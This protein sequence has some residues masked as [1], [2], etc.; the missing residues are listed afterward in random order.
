M[1]HVEGTA[2]ISHQDRI[3]LVKFH[4]SNLAE[5][6]AGR[7]AQNRASCTP[8]RYIGA[9]FVTEHARLDAD[10]VA[11]ALR[12]GVALPDAPSARQQQELDE[13]AEKTGRH[14]DR[15][16]LYL[17]IAGH[18]EALH[19]IQQQLWHGK[20]AEVKQLASDAE[21]LIRHHLAL[22]RWALTVC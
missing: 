10:L 12:H 22:V 3:F 13:I 2:R 18:L 9:V 17:Q 5:I 16:W 6:V 21:P 19:L 20:S 8:L 11:V 15:A 1:S 14:F 4:Q 7:L